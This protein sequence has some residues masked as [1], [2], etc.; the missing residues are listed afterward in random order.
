MI[1]ILSMRV[2]SVALYLNPNITQTL[3]MD[4]IQFVAII[5]STF[6]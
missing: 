4:L 3:N 6:N 2:E 1:L 5:V